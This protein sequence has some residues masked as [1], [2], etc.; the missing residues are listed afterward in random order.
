[1][2]VPRVDN[3]IPDLRVPLRAALRPGSHL[4]EIAFPSG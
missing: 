4:D 1:M 3:V 2:I